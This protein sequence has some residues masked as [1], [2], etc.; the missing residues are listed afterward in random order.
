M[1]N[2]SLADLLREIRTFRDAREWERYHTVRHL[3]AALSIEAAEVQ[4]VLLWK[5]DEEV[6]TSLEDGAFRT[7]LGHE[8]ADVLIYSLLLCHACGLEG[9]T[10]IREKLQLNA[11]KYPV[12][13]ARGS[14][15]KYTDL[16]S[17]SKAGDKR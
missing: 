8:I 17:P 10:V 12:E 13:L 1:P 11:E 3:A 6:S 16:S 5:T 14:A 4:E 7:R 9:A 2:D 15:K